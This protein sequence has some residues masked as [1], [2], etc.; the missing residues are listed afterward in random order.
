MDKKLPKVYENKI[1]KNLDNNK[2]VYYSTEKEEVKKEK[3]EVNIKQKI[4]DIFNSNRYIY[5][6]DVV[7]KKKDG[8]VTKKIIGKNDFDLIT[9]DNE[10]IPISDILDIKYKD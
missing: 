5:K 9:I 8:E 2:K 4:N 1:D 6:A 7:I 10:L 3:E